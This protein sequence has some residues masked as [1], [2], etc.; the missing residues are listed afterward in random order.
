[1]VRKR[2]PLLTDEERL[3]ACGY[4]PMLRVGDAYHENLDETRAK[5]ILD[6]LE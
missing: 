4:A 2:E 3:G 1:M 5:E 6:A